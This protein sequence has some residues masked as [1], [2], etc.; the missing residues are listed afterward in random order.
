MLCNVLVTR[1]PPYVVPT[2]VR[3][4]IVVSHSLSI[5]L[6]FFFFCEVYYLKQ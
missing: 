1:G 2:P 6:P 4:F 5:F 3:S